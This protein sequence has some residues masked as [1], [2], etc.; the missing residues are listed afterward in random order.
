MYFNLLHRLRWQIF[1]F[2]LIRGRSLLGSWRFETGNQRCYWCLRRQK[3]LGYFELHLML[4]Q[5]LEADLNLLLLER[6]NLLML[7]AVLPL[8]LTVPRSTLDFSANGIW[9]VES[10]SLRYSAE[11]VPADICCWCCSFADLYDFMLNWATKV[12]GVLTSSSLDMLVFRTE[13]LLPFVPILW[14]PALSAAVLGV[15]SRSAFYQVALSCTI[16]HCFR[17]DCRV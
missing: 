2:C 16:F 6:G 9:E 14:M 17:D 12:S 3:P 10:D 4:L 11:D 7:Y 5:V 13:W 8:V 15:V 1:A